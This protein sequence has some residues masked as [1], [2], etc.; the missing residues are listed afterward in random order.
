MIH[1]GIMIEASYILIGQGTAKYQIKIH[2]HLQIPIKSRTFIAM[3]CTVAS[4]FV[5]R[6]Y[7]CSTRLIEYHA[8]QDA[9]RATIY[10]PAAL[11]IAT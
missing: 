11:N 8:R 7:F 4:R 2:V 6:I 10:L 5:V 9:F 1:D 3:S